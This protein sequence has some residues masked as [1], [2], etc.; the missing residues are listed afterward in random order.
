MFGQP[1]TIIQP[2]MHKHRGQL[3]HFKLLLQSGEWLGN[4]TRLA[5]A[6]GAG[7]K[8]SVISGQGLPCIATV[9]LT[10][11]FPPHALSSKVF[12]LPYKLYRGSLGLR[13]KKGN[14]SLPPKV[15]PVTGKLLLRSTADHAPLLGGPSPTNCCLAVLALPVEDNPP[16]RE[17]AWV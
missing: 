1:R 6:L 9:F 14:Y 2:V 5:C 8:A 4:V 11:D 3:I 10:V 12:L 15:L 7:G 16:V 13:A 17:N